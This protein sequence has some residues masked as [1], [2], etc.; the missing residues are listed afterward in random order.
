MKEIYEKIN[1]YLNDIC[2]FLEQDNSFLLDNKLTF[3]D[4]YLLAR[5][6]IETIDFNYLK[7][8]DK[9]IETGE[10]DFSYDKEY[11]GSYC[12]TLIKDGK[13]KIQLININRHFNYDDVVTLIH[14]FIHYTNTKMSIFLLNFYLFI[15]KLTLSIIY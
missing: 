2:T 12:H 15:L 1:K 7:D 6:I 5:E 4:V 11:I 9:L 10:L 14:E 3:E 13:L 8:F